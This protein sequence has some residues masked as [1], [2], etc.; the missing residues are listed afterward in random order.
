MGLP[1]V[2]ERP[3]SFGRYRLLER[4]GA[5]G[6]AVV[7]RALT[8]GNDGTPRELVIKRV[9]PQLSCDPRFSAM[10]VAEARI[11]ERLRHPN[12]VQLYELGRVGD[13][14]Y[15]AME[16]VDG[17][18]LVQVLNG[19]LRAKNPLPIAL[20]CHIAVELAR[21]LAYAHDL[22]DN[23]DRPLSIVHRDISPSNVMVTRAGAV[24]LLDFGVAKAAEHVRD[25]RTRTG[26]LKGKVNYLS[27]ESA[28][29][30]PV[31]RRSDIFALGILLHECLTLQRLFKAE[32]DLMT[33]RL[34]REANVAP[35]SQLRPEVMPELDSV[36]MKMLARAP[37]ARYGNCQQLLS[38]LA[39][40]AARLGGNAGE[41]ARLIATLPAS[42]A[43][44]EVGEDLDAGSTPAIEIASLDVAT[45]PERAPTHRKWLWP[46]IAIA[47]ST[48]LTTALV[49]SHSRRAT[50]PPSPPLVVT[51]PPV[52]LA[53]PPMSPTPPPVAKASPAT[54]GLPSVARVAAPELP[55]MLII[56]MDVSAARIALDGKVVADQV[57]RA[58]IPILRPGA[59]ELTI[60]APRRRPFTRRLTIAPGAMLEMR[61]SLTRSHTRVTTKRGR[62]GNYL[63]DPF[64]N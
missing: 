5:G 38:E 45:V 1:V 34:I 39:P 18:D 64:A 42:T 8:D 19:C 16:L 62:D 15:L 44:L 14:F 10:L 60:T 35:P 36:V 54:K 6:M 29:G 4:L 21:A 7:Y 25:D 20:A 47:M 24:K 51:A 61:V 28:D 2:E 43:T 32:G 3:V 30:R 49:L 58:R 13:E 23:D 9:L 50:L 56:D 41:L 46:A 40:I 27:P 57:R 33:L 63:V 31:D 48:L 26:M 11:S 55:G 52:A 22:R 17:I 59:H 37:E 12:I 53:P